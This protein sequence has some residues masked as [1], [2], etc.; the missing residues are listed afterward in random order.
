MFLACEVPSVT[1]DSLRKKSESLNVAQKTFPGL[2]LSL[3]LHF[4]PP[5]TLQAAK[6]LHLMAM[7]PILEREW[8]KNPR[9]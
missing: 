9:K 4:P 5:P 1:L 2:A 8:K 6:H 3:Q 7:Q